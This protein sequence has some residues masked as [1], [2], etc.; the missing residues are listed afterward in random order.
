LGAALKVS[1]VQPKSFTQWLEFAL[2]A[3]LHEHF[4]IVLDDTSAHPF[5][6]SLAEKYREQVVTLRPQL[7]MDNAMQQVASMGNPNDPGVQYRKAFM[8]LVQAI[9]KRKEK[10][11]KEAGDLC[12]A[13]AEENIP[14]NP[15]WVGQVIAVYAALANDQVGY[16]NFTK[17]IT[18]ADKGVKA[19]EQ[20]RSIIKDEYIFCKL[21]AQAIM[22]RASLFAAAKEWL[23]AV[24][25]FDL[26]AKLYV[27]ANDTILAMEAYRMCAYC[28]DKAGNA[29]EACIAL[30]QALAAS[31]NLPAHIIKATTFAGVIELLIQ[32]NNLKHI[33]P[34]EVEER[35]R[36]VYG[37][38]WLLEI[39]NW[40]NPVYKTVDD[41]A[42]SVVA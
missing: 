10:E 13:I 37:D 30:V 23:N 32:V 15:Y 40:K 41:A 33:S 25:D 9:E 5:Y 38:D 2:K 8:L 3:G 16:R 14:K 18:Y 7:D 26:S 11:A 31:A 42:L 36:E 35:A 17:A 28:N 1:F 19:A 21:R 27:S 29:N 24:Q 39:N 20:S 22:L 4:K 6:D 34:L 12:I